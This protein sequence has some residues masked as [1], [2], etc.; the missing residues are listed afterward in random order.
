MQHY[1][2]NPIQANDLIQNSV[3]Q[4]SDYKRLAKYQIICV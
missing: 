2:I 1:L 3:S 4:L